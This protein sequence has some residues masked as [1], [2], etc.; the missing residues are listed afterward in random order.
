MAAIQCKC[1]KTQNHRHRTGKLQTKRA[2]T[3]KKS[4]S[5]MTRFPEHTCQKVPSVS[6]WCRCVSVFLSSRTLDRTVSVIV[7]GS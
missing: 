1:K 5:H 2:T 4:E 6:S 7:V 3:K